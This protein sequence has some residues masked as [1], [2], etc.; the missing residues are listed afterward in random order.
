VSGRVLPWA[1]AGGAAAIVALL[2]I[3]R[4]FRNSAEPPAGSTKDPTHD[5]P[6]DAELRNAGLIYRAVGASGERYPDWVRAL[7][8]KS[9]VYVI[10]QIQRDGSE[11]VVYVGESHSG[12]LYDTLTRHLQTVRHEAQEVPMT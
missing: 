4:S 10:K 1:L 5:L 9:G 7:D 11:E 6:S 8:G 12:R 3:R 2:A